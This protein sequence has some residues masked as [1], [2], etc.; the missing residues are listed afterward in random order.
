[1]SAGKGVIWRL[2]RKHVSA[3][4]LAGFS[5]AS[6]VG[7]SIVA[8]AAQFWCD[9]RPIFTAD[10]SFMSR[11]YL[12]ITNRVAPMGSLLGSNPVFSED[13]IADIQ[14]Q[15]W[16]RKVGRFTASQYDVV[17]S[18][19]MGGR[20]MSTKLFFE[21]IPDEFLDVSPAQW[22]FNPRKP[23]I[24]V[25]VSKDYLSLY[26][27]GFAAAQNLPKVSESMVGMVPITLTLRGAGRSETLQGRIVGFSNRLNTVVVPEEFM[28]WSN[29][30][31]SGGKLPQPSRLIVEVNSPGDIRI[32]EY[33]AE[34][35]YEVAGDKADSGRA[36]YLLTVMSVTVGAVGAV[37]TLLAFFVLALSVSLLLQKNT[38]KLRNLLLLGYSPAEVSAPYVKL[39]SAVG[40]GVLALSAAAALAVRAIYLPALK[41][42]G[43]AGATPLVSVAVAVAVSALITAG[44]V[45]IIRRRVGSLWR[46]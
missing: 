39:V 5:A 7:M 32:S 3:G 26:N 28:R 14:A 15:P 2:L 1:M 36:S 25:I 42:I 8:V 12:V 6:L 37:I 38:D 34:H 22:G 44:N 33:L 46:S 19:G 11:D 16:A 23:E 30:R 18:V 40:L 13:D 43:D 35:G 27:F 31:Y 10:D 24:P 4:Q 41:A 45:A 21:S 9:V 17:A 29:A 20:S